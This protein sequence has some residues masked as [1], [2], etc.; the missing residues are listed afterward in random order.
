MTI[1][2][3]HKLAAHHVDQGSVDPM[4]TSNGHCCHVSV[5]SQPDTQRCGDLVS[6]WVR[7][8][9]EQL[10]GNLEHI[11]FLQQHIS[12]QRWACS[13]HIALWWVQCWQACSAG[14]YAFLTSVSCKLNDS[15]Y[16]H[17]A[18]NASCSCK[19]IVDRCGM[20]EVMWLSITCSF[21]NSVFLG[22]G[23]LLDAVIVLTCFVSLFRAFSIFSCL[24]WTRSISRLVAMFAW[25]ALMSMNRSPS[26]ARVHSCLHIPPSIITYDC[27]G[28]QQEVCGDEAQGLKTYLLRL[29]QEQC[30]LPRR[31]CRRQTN[32][33]RC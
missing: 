20:S 3:S 4:V 21:V 22:P 18:C 11:L 30:S 5:G 8:Y 12:D 31:S 17:M 24:R 9:I 19:S 28:L 13:S 6:L 29:D 14:C 32:Q 15:T 26:P 10:L 1:T 2:G 25:T 7:V 33:N 27:A 23:V 16:D